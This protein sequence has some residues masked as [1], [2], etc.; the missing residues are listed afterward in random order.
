MLDLNELGLQSPRTNGRTPKAVTAVERRELGPADLQSR[1]VE[2]GGG[3][4]SLK[5]LSTKHHNLARMLAQG[6]RVAEAAPAVG[7]TPTRV[8]MLNAD[9]AFKELV[10]FYKRD[11]DIAWMD[12]HEKLAALS[13]DAV[14]EL[15]DRLENDP[16]SMDDEML[17]SLV[18][19]G[20]DRTGYGPSSS[21]TQT[22]KVSVG[23]ADRLS[24][25]RKRVSEAN[26]ARVIEHQE[27]ENEPVHEE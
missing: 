14:E 6:V 5:R 19:L 10:A 18:T 17:K 22:V 9:P 25:A 27:A 12:M 15:S 11:L 24:A 4:D 26:E 7:Y 3:A 23:L 13:S 21:T 16:E 1:E 2:I 8:S 20:A